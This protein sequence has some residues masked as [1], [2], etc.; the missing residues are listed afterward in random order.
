M[1][2]SL[3]F[4]FSLLTLS[5]WAQDGIN[6]QGAATDANG[7]ELTNQNIT[8]RASVLSTS[9]NGNLEWEETHSATTDQFGLFNVVIGQGTN[10]SNGSTSNFDNMDWGSGNHFLKIEMD[11]TGGTNYAM[12]GTTQMMSV[13]YA[14]YAKSAGI[15]STMIADMIGASGGCTSF[16]SSTNVILN[17][18][19][20]Y[21]TTYFEEAQEDGFFGGQ[22]NCGSQYQGAFYVYD[23]TTSN[24]VY[25]YS[26]SNGVA[27]FLIPIKEGQY[28]SA[29]GSCIDMNFFIPLD[30]GGGGGSSS[31][32]TGTISVSTFGDTL[33]MNGQ[34]IIV[35]GISYQNYVPTF[36]SVTDISGNTYQT[37]T[38]NGKEWMID[39]LRVTKFSNGDDINQITG[40]NNWNN[41]NCTN[42]GYIMNSSF[43]TF[44]F[45]V[46][47]NLPAIRDSRNICPNGWHVATDQ[48]YMQVLDVF[49]A[50]DTT[51]AYYLTNNWSGYWFEWDNAGPEL[52]KQN[53][54][55]NV[56]SGYPAGQATN[57]S[58]LGFESFD[59]TSC[60]NA[61]NFFGI[62]TDHKTWTGTPGGPNGGNW[63]LKLKSSEDRV[64][65]SDG[66]ADTMLPCRCV[67]D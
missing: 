55:W 60:T 51:P 35:P 11:A 17:W 26:I 33:T 1:K 20:N 38:I 21:S 4:I 45:K 39:D 62:N 49:S 59:G 16:G 44:G 42:P 3:L 32:N 48:D 2:K 23:D 47:Y 57:E 14:L 34:S 25:N 19:E 65:F 5:L 52:K 46:W 41:S 64:I 63:Y 10:T 22:M 67:K 18:D 8:L 29:S 30:C 58:Y 36:G 61:N 43:L 15:D 24:S 54:D 27:T 66:S 50:R 9:A 6:Y 37:I 13:P 31:T 56:S 7:D 28:W 12:I 40:T 53:G